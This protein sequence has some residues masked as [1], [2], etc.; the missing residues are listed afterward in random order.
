M[1]GKFTSHLW[2]DLFMCD[3]VKIRR[4]NVEKFKVAILHLNSDW[5]HCSGDA[6]NIV[7]VLQGLCQP[8]RK[9]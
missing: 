9:N 8:K 4:C 5:N 1:L 7:K 3:T 2:R 6:G